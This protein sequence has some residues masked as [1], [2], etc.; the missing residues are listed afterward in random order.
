MGDD[1]TPTVQNNHQRVVLRR[2]ISL[3]QDA[4]EIE[5]TWPA[6]WRQ[7]EAGELINHPAIS[8][9]IQTVTFDFVR[10]AIVLNLK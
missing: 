8:G 3:S 4:E 1:E 6:L 10:G 9:F 2:R 5:I 7:P